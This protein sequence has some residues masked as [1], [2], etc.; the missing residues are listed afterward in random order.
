[1][2][3]NE[4]TFNHEEHAALRQLRLRWLVALLIT[5]PMPFAVLPITGSDWVQQQPDGSASNTMLFAILIGGAAVV[6]GLF[7]RNQL[8]KAN[9]Q[10]NLVTPAGY[11]KANTICFACILAGAI[12][13]FILSVI[14]RYPAPTFAAAPIFIGLLIFNVPTG[15]PMRPTPPRIGPDGGAS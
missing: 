11:L 3:P 15:R 6:A 4:H 13:L 5:A 12:G 14:T 1:M 8:Y 2:N 9:W 7:T 10:G